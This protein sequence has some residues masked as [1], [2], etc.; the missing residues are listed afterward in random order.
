MTNHEKLSRIEDLLRDR[1]L[2]EKENGFIESFIKDSENNVISSI[3]VYYG[4]HGGSILPSSCG[5]A[6]ISAVKTTIEENRL[7]LL[8]IEKELNEILNTPSI[9]SKN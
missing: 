4:T 9:E 2:I 8:A 5:D 1:S 6:L 3:E 7:K